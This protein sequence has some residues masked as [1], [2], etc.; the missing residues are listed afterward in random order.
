M[1]EGLISLLVLCL[2][3]ALSTHANIL[4]EECLCVYVK[5]C[6][7]MMAAMEAGISIPDYFFKSNYEEKEK[8]K[9]KGP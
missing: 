6:V 3:L 2:S 4:L 9:L 7:T 8:K 5:L 1:G